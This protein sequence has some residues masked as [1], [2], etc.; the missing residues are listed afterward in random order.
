MSTYAGIRKS[1][2]FI[3]AVTVAITACFLSQ[4]VVLARAQVLHLALAP[5][6]SFPIKPAITKE[7]EIREEQQFLTKMHVLFWNER[8]LR[9]VGRLLSYYKENGAISELSGKCMVILLALSYAQEFVGP[10]CFDLFWSTLKFRLPFMKEDAPEIMAIPDPQSRSTKVC[11]LLIKREGLHV[12]TDQ[13]A[14]V[15]KEIE[16]LWAIFGHGRSVEEQEMRGIVNRYGGFYRSVGCGLDKQRRDLVAGFR[17]R[18]GKKWKRDISTFAIGVT[19]QCPEKCRHCLVPFRVNPTQDR[20][21]ASKYIDAWLSFAESIGAQ[22]IVVSGGEPLGIQPDSVAKIVSKSKLPVYV[23]TSADFAKDMKTIE[24]L[25]RKIWEAAKDKVGKKLLATGEPFKVV[26]QLSFDEFHQHITRNPHGVLQEQISTSNLAN[27]IQVIAEKF[28]GIEIAMFIGATPVRGYLEEDGT[29]HDPWLAF[30]FR[31]LEIRGYKIK[32]RAV[33]DPFHLPR[34]VAVRMADGRVQTR[35]FAQ[36]LSVEMESVKSGTSYAFSA[37]YNL[38]MP[39]GWAAVLDE[40][41][42][43]YPEPLPEEFLEG[44]LD[45]NHGQYISDPGF[46][47]VSDGNVYNDA[48]LLNVWSMGNAKEMDI[49]TIFDLYQSDPLVYL[50]QT[51]LQSAI[52]IASEVRPTLREE[53]RKN[54]YFSTLLLSLFS[55]PAL[56]LYMTQRYIQILSDRREIEP[57]VLA[58]L[59]L[60]LPVAELQEQYHAHAQ[61]VQQTESDRFNAEQRLGALF[62][63]AL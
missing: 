40:G 10:E 6:T 48:A 27:V 59:G 12:S 52:S 21:L 14:L 8:L 15:L 5:Q 1:K 34:Q 25:L 30:L 11:D 51:S 43:L 42:F 58:K 29:I 33:A 55:D 41:E 44:T 26:I 4:N 28:P 23:T 54:P 20:V 36:L 35:L 61:P 37:Q 7:Q 18:T 38:V 56:R 9:R 31:K 49:A 16:K 50:M 3:E 53:L 13:R 2:R 63:G 47:I 32:M 22:N 57:S 24:P 60:T 19:Q 46:E 39:I 45:I 17:Q 62:K